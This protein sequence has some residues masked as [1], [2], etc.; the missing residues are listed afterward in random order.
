MSR[1]VHSVSYEIEGTLSNIA[2][3]LLQM[4]QDFE[5]ATGIKD[6]TKVHVYVIMTK[7]QG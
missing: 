5:E 6:T 1:K 4:I 7:I 3:S 2:P